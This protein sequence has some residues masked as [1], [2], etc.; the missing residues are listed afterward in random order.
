MNRLARLGLTSAALL[1]ALS[2]TFTSEYAS[3]EAALN[4]PVHV[5]FTI[6][7]QEVLTVN[8]RGNHLDVGSNNGNILLVNDNLNTAN[9]FAL[10][11]NTNVS[12]IIS[13]QDGGIVVAT[14]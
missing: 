5:H 9:M 2:G 7:V 12:V 10:S 3:A 14:P 8:L 4:Q 1:L 6:K 13:S 11:G